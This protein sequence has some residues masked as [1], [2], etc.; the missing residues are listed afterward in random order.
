MTVAD[1]RTADRSRDLARSSDRIVVATTTECELART[2]R[3]QCSRASKEMENGRAV[4]GRFFGPS[5]PFS[6][7]RVPQLTGLAELPFARPFSCRGPL[8]RAP[9]PRLGET[10]RSLP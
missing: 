5:T 9:R 10:A 8:D 6:R 3:M 2:P 1:A 4:P 7:L